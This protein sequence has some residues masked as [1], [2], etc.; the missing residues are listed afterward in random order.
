MNQEIHKNRLFHIGSSQL[1]KGKVGKYMIP[2]TTTVGFAR[3]FELW[4]FSNLIILGCGLTLLIAPEQ[5][6]VIPALLLFAGFLLFLAAVIFGL[7][8]WEHSRLLRIN[9]ILIG[10]GSLTIFFSSL[11]IMNGPEGRGFLPIITGFGI[12]IVWIGSLSIG[13]KWKYLHTKER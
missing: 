10:I 4:G 11:L 8:Y 12:V 2:K 3:S 9:T 7:T 5:S 1:F 6:K 13:L